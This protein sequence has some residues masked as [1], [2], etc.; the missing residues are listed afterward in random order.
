METIYQKI[1]KAVESA[2]IKHIVY[3]EG[4]PMDMVELDFNPMDEE[5]ESDDSLSPLV[6][7]MR[8]IISTINAEAEIDDDIR[9]CFCHLPNEEDFG[10]S[11]GDGRR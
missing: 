6:R 1:K 7:A 5:H 4:Y 9:V 2:N 10:I 11:I 8:V 3:K